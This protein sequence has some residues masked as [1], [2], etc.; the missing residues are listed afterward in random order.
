RAV[1]AE[2]RA[3]LLP[4]LWHVLSGSSTSSSQRWRRSGTRCTS[5]SAWARRPGAPRAGGSRRAR[6]P[7]RSPRRGLG[8]PGRRAP[9]ARAH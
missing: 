7:S 2:A 8:V 5:T 9:R 6:C 3:G 1:H 4:G